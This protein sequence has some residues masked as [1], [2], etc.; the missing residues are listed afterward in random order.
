MPI[1]WQPGPRNLID[2]LA[3][4]PKIIDVEGNAIVEDLTAAA[5]SCSKHSTGIFHCTNGT[6]RAPRPGR[7]L[8][9][10]GRLAHTNEWIREEDLVGQERLRHRAGRTTSAGL[11]PASRRSAS[12][13]GRWLATPRHDGQ[14]AKAVGAKKATPATV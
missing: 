1:D 2:K 7:A 14:Y 13:C 3:K 6:R 10:A 9:R 12:R 5:P 8:Q 11:Q 4:Y